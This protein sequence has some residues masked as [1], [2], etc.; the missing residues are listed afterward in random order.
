MENQLA[1]ALLPMACVSQQRLASIRSKCWAANGQSWKSSW[2]HI[3][4]S[5]SRSESQRVRRAVSSLLVQLRALSHTILLK[6]LLRHASKLKP[7][8]KVIFL[9]ARSSGISGPRA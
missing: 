9:L 7:G 6:S 2:D 1:G 4:I 8:S 5:K 3:S